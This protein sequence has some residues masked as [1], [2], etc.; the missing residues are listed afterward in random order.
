MNNT[1]ISE[2]GYNETDKVNTPKLKAGM[3]PVY[4]DSGIWK[5]ADENNTDKQWYDY[6]NKKWANIVTVADSDS[7]LRDA[8]VGTEIPMEKITTFFVWIPRYA[9]SI[10]SGYQKGSTENGSIDITFLKGNTNVGVDGNIYGTDYDETKLSAGDTTPKIVHPG[11]SFDNRELTGIWVAKF[12]ASGTN[13]SGQAVGNANS[14][15]STPVAV[16]TSTYVKILPSVVSWRHITIGETE[17]QSMRMS[18]N[19]EKY[20]W[21]IIKHNRKCIWS[22]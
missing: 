18:S 4:Y 2:N 13:A 8:E 20:G 7:K 6:E 5:K 19:T 9:Y 12:E 14:E 22:I 21:T 10:T 3:I 11:F 16:D 15:S 1:T 17:Y